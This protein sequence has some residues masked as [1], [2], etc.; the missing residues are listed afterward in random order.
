METKDYM[1]EFLKQEANTTY[2]EE[3]TE[4]K[5]KD[6]DDEH[7]AMGEHFIVTAKI[8]VSDFSFTSG[9]Q[10]KTVKTKCLVNAEIFNNFV[11]QHKAI[12]WL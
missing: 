9:N 11:K 2:I 3:V 5:I 12:I 8:H 1:L 10:T 4:V 6:F 7:G